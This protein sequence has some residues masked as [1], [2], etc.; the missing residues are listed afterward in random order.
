MPSTKPKT[1]ALD[2]GSRRECHDAFTQYDRVI[3][4]RGSVYSVSIGRVE[5]REQIR[6]FLK[7][8]KKD[9]RY[10]AA[11]HNTYAARVVGDGVVYETKGDDGE[12]GA[13]QVVLRELQKADIAQVCVCVTRWFGGVKLMGDR[14]KH[15]QN[16]ARYGLERVEAGP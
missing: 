10:A 13:G 7:H 3:H 6:G 4:D 12:V 2:L 15:V 5:N 11:T 1:L 8:I 16:A 9:A 14:F